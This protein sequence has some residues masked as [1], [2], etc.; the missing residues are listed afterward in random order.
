MDGVLHFAGL[1][2]SLA[3]DARY[4]I[5]APRHAENIESGSTTGHPTPT[6]SDCEQ[7]SDSR[8]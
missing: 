8:R 2:A 3:F 4:I 6:A 7:I 1:L 5:V